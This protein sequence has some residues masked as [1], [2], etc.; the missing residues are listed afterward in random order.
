VVVQASVDADLAS[1]VGADV[2]PITVSRDAWRGELVGASDSIDGRR[3]L[4]WRLGS[5]VPVL[6]VDLAALVAAVGILGVGWRLGGVAQGLLLVAFPLAVTVLLGVLGLYGRGARLDTLDT[7]RSVTVATGIVTLAIIAVPPALD[8]INRSQGLQLWLASTLLLGTSRMLLRAGGRGR[9]RSVAKPTLIIGA[10]HVG[11]ILE[12]RMQSQPELGLRAMG[13]LDDDPLVEDRESSLPV[14]GAYRDLDRVVAQYRIKHAIVGFSTAPHHVLLS[15]VRRCQELGV[16]VSLVP[17]LF[18]VVTRQTSVRHLGGLP[19]VS[20]HP[21]DPRGI[22]LSIKYALDRIGALALLLVCFP[23]LSV[24][25]LV[26]WVSLGRPILFGQIRVGRDGHRFE[27]LKFRSMRDREVEDAELHPTATASVEERCTRLGAF[28]RRTSLDE[29]PQLINII[30]GDMSFVGPRP[31]QPELVADFAQRIYRYGDRHRVK[32][33]ITGWAQI[34]G[35]GR[36]E[37]RFGIRSLSERAEWDNYYIEN[38]SPWLDIKILC[39][40]PFAVTHFRQTS[41]GVATHET[42][43]A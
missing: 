23:L 42:P 16:S 11:R 41:S 24:L 1:T 4:L 21:A 3:D 33:G 36:G 27:I 34:H 25:S 17:R 26:V 7:L 10:G 30:K 15:V 5:R 9:R 28:L 39:L 32:S 37:E 12:R 14:L 18:E 13:F 31:E 40:T 22:G 38:W 20:I 19:L 29:L 43:K 2:D 6:V 35:I 8:T